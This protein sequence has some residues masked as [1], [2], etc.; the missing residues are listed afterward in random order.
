[1]L[2]LSLHLNK[3]SRYIT[4]SSNIAIHT[5]YLLIYIIPHSTNNLRKY[6][7]WYFPQIEKKG[8][9]SCKLCRSCWDSDSLAICLACYMHPI[10]PSLQSSKSTLSH[11]L[12]R[13]KD[14]ILILPKQVRKEEWRNFHDHPRRHNQSQMPNFLNQVDS[15]ICH[16]NEWCIYYRLL[17]N[18]IWF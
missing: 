11:F 6:V 1:M 9:K 7:V 2:V 18:K 14:S 15:L 10:Q 17:I 12:C 5:A 3:H 16:K 13:S 8:V 4:L